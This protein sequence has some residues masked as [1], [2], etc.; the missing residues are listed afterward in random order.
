MRA[1]RRGA[2]LL[3]RG[4]AVLAM[5]G[6]VGIPG[7]VAA[8]DRQRSADV[9]K[10]VAEAEAAVVARRYAEAVDRYERAWALLPEPGF[11]FNISMLY[12]NRL[13]DPMRAWDHAVLFSGAAGTD[14]D[15]EDAAE[16]LEKIAAEL[17]KTRARVALEVSPAHAD[18]TL[19][20]RSLAIRAPQTAWIPA[21]RHAVVV[22]APGFRT[23]ESALVLEAGALVPLKI[24]LEPAGGKLRV[25]AD[26]DDARVTIDD[27]PAVAAPAE[28]IVSPGKHVVQVEAG[29]RKT[30]RREIQV[31][32]AE[33]TVVHAELPPLETPGNWRKTAGWISIG[34]AGAAVAAGLTTW[35]LGRKEATAAG[36][37]RPEDYDR[38]DAY[39]DAF[40]TRVERARSEGIAS[41]ALWGIGAAAAGVG[42]YFLLA[43]GGGP[44]VSVAPGP[45]GAGLSASVAW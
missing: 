33:T 19:D 3:L 27:H 34:T 22:S 24:R 30:F 31:G 21:G 25:S 13:Q 35:F 15:R 1:A 4:I 43:P 26:A 2:G 11:Q 10:L 44:A 12:L 32:P 40:N 38:Y 8:Q 23:D 37:L 9:Q 7:P 5:L 39:K 36:N 6:A 17:G 42:L 45:G 28:R 20:G 16:L 14:L 41:Y 18:V 29:G